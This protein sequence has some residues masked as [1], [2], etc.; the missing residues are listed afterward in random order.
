MNLTTFSLHFCALWAIE[1]FSELNK[2]LKATP[3]IH[4]SILRTKL[5]RW[6]N[7]VEQVARIFP[8]MI[9]TKINIETLTYGHNC[10]CKTVRINCNTQLRR[11]RSKQKS[12]LDKII[13]T[14]AIR[15]ARSIVLD[16][17]KWIIFAFNVLTTVWHLQHQ[18]KKIYKRNKK[19]KRRTYYFDCR[20]VNDR[21]VYTRCQQRYTIKRNK[22][23]QKKK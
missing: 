20:K 18:E 2:N 13:T 8:F 9:K 22:F 11:R 14:Y 23:K 3:H 6:I 19:N 7:C 5:H 1:S 17:S 21:K 15:L 16:C 10:S 4:T 12:L